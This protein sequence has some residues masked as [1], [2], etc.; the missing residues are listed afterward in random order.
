[1]RRALCTLLL[2]YA[3]SV[4][5]TTVAETFR[6]Y[7]TVIDVQPIMDTVYEPVTREVCD[8]PDRSTR[9]IAPA[10]ASIG[11]DIREQQRLWNAQRSCTTVTEQQPRE[12]VTAYRVTYRYRGYTSTTRLAYH[13]GERMPVN[14]NLS[15]MP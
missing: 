4:S 9:V 11:E 6:S 5:G 1:M 2:W 7:A 10:A 8:H 13:P 12:Q 14:V 3:W 15:P